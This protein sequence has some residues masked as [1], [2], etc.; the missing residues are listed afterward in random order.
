MMLG[1]TPGTLALNV[2][3]ISKVL[4]AQI[5]EWL[6]LTQEVDDSNRI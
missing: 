2:D 1:L 5:E 3:A 6:L 4:V